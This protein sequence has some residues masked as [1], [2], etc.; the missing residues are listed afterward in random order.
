MKLLLTAFEPFGGETVNPAQLAVQ[1]L[2]ERVDEVELLRCT[3]PV[4]FG[5]AVQVVC[6]AI[7]QHQ[8]DAVLCVGQAGGRA[9]IP[10]ERVAINC[11]DARIP[12]NAG[13][14]PVDRPVAADGPAA[15]FATL[16]IKAMAAAIRQAGVPAAVSNTAGT[17]VCN[18]L[19]YG[20]LHHLAQHRPGVRGGFVHLPLTAQQAAAHGP[21]TPGLPLEQLVAGLTAA[22][23][24]IGQTTADLA[25]T[26]GA[27]C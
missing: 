14:Q 24:A 27:E 13:A 1:A 2:P 25:A 10:P 26:E 9:A 11:D 22:V 16:P 8:P 20:V 5:R 21:N 15:Y 4:E 7:E 17:Y 18:H 23:R 19:M 3:V 12:D 6:A